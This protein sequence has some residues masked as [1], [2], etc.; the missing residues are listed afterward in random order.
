ELQH[1][2]LR[3]LLDGRL[4]LSPVIRP[5]RA[6][7]VGTGPG[8]WALVCLSR[9]PECDV[10]GIDIDPVRPPSAV[11]NCRFLVM[12]ATE[13]WA[14][15]EK[16]DFIHVRMVGDLPGKNKLIQSIFE[17][18]N[19]GGWVEF[20]EWIVLL[21]SPD[22]SFDGS[23]FHKWNCL[24]LKGKSGASLTRALG[25]RKLGSSVFYPTE[26]KALLQKAG[27][28]HVT[29][30]KHAAMT[31]PCY[32]GKSM[33]RLGALMT[34]NWM[35]VIEPLSVPVFA[36]LGW[37]PEKTKSLLVDVRK[38]ISDPRFHSFMTLMTVYCQ[39]PTEE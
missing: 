11:P 33:Q 34:S 30:R 3:E 35:G 2:V 37:S 17:N 12:D 29:E 5:A 10:V 39:K 36:S 7:D 21:Q 13:D 22:H 15:E 31:N 9:H 27:F 26:Y 19:P 20:T 38:E 8:S 18:L 25:L 6:L 16:F 24:L 4:H 1:K 28:D 23:A 32:P 14:F